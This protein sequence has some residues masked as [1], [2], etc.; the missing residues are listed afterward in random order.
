MTRDGLHLQQWVIG[1]EV[2]RYVGFRQPDVGDQRAKPAVGFDNTF[3]MLIAT[4]SRQVGGGA[5]QQAEAGGGADD[6]SGPELDQ[7]R[8]L[9]RAR[10]RL[11]L[12]SAL[13]PVYRG[14][15]SDGARSG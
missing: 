6:V 13:A 10:V 1:P 8:F 5:D 9:G 11:R 7:A 4:G 3:K 15:A 2:D 14:M 12:P